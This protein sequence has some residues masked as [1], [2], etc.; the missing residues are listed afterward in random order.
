MSQ[1]SASGVPN[2]N[3]FVALLILSQARAANVLSTH[4][5]IKTGKQNK[6]EDGEKGSCAV[7]G[8]KSNV[9]RKCTYIDG[10]GCGQ[11]RLLTTSL[12][13]QELQS[14][15]SVVFSLLPPFCCGFL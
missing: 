1:L 12:A 15:S 5:T 10:G 14:N 3:R 7:H 8:A 9:Q 4:A 6:R 11:Q 13:C 2:Q